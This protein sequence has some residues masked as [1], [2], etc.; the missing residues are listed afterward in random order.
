MFALGF[1]EST[2]DFMASMRK[3]RGIALFGAIGPFTISYVV[4]DFTWNEPA[5]S[6]LCALAMTATV[7][8]LR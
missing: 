8:S 4:T 7:V 6:L 1:D 2:E 3:S 5:T